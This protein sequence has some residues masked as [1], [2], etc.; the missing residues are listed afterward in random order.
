MSSIITHKPPDPGN[1]YENLEDIELY[2]EDGQPTGFFLSASRHKPRPYC[3]GS[4]G[5]DDQ[6]VD[7]SDYAV[8]HS[9]FMGPAGGPPSDECLRCYDYDNDG[10][11]D[12]HDFS[13]FQR[14]F[15]GAS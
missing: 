7:L 12:E 14:D 1:L 4:D 6:D 8:F 9:C 10:D 15:T 13:V 5:Y 2:D 3:H 11:V